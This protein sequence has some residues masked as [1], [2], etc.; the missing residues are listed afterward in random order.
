MKVLAV[1]TASFGFLAVA[2]GA[3]GAHALQRIVEPEMLTVW[4][5]A[6]QYQ[7]FHVLVLLSIIIADSRT[8]NILLCVSGWLF[9]V[10]TLLFSGSLYLLVVTGVKA[11]GMITPIGGVLFL[12]GWLVLSLALVKFITAQKSS[13][14]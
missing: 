4:Q 12:V 10:G 9:V 13:D 3:F 7:M 1:I 6:V 11:L 8:S 2:L 5:T 14:Q